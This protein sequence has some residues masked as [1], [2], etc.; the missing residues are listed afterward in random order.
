MD[1]L[2]K[3]QL[4]KEFHQLFANLARGEDVGLKEAFDTPGVATRKSFASEQEARSYSDTI[5]KLVAAGFVA[6][7]STGIGAKMK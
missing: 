7:I 6:E 5:Q 3:Y 1:D 4:K 2:K